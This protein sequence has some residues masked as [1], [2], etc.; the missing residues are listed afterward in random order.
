MQSRHRHKYILR[1]LHEDFFRP[2]GLNALVLTW[3]P[4]SSERSIDVDLNQ[5]IIDNLLPA[6]GLLEKVKS[7]FRPSMGNTVGVAFS[8]TAPLVFPELDSLVNDRSTEA[9][10]FKEKVKK[11]KGLLVGYFG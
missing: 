7:N 2:R 4:E 11:N 8:E 1:P 3:K 9:K 6:D 5:T 10:S